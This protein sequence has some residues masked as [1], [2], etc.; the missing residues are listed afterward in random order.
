MFNVKLVEDAIKAAKVS[1]AAHK[2]RALSPVILDA[3]E[4]VIDEE[5]Y[6][7]LQTQ[8]TEGLEMLAQIENSI[9]STV[10]TASSN[11]RVVLEAKAANRNANA[12]ADDVKIGNLLL[13]LQLE[14]CALLKRSVLDTLVQNQL[15]AKKPKKSAE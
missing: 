7:A 4:L 9:L 8:L 2:E 3:Q 5:E 10:N 6:N 14:V 1:L 13:E 15:I 12:S 11:V